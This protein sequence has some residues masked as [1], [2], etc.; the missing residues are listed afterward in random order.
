MKS[1]HDIKDE[2]MKFLMAA[3]SIL[4]LAGCQTHAVKD[5]AAINDF[6]SVKQ[7]TQIPTIDESM[8]TLDMAE[9]AR[10]H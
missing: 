4:V 6:S 10:R 1:S 2:M 5:Q 8:A 3:L 7:V 9:F